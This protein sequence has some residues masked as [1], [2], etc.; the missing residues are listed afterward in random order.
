MKH[1]CDTCQY[2]GE[3]REMGF[4]PQ[5]VCTKEHDLLKAMLAYRAKKCPFVKKVELEPCPFCGKQPR[6]FEGI[7]LLDGASVYQVFCNNP[8]CKKHASTCFNPTKQMAID[9]WNERVKE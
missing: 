6:I 1:K 3:H 8:D 2:K 9:E 5:G 4:K 7:V